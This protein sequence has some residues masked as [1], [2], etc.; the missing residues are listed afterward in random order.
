MI[1]LNLENKKIYYTSASFQAP[2]DHDIYVE[3]TK[4]LTKPGKV[5]L[6]KLALFI[7]Y[8]LKDTPGAYFIHTMTKLEELGFYQSNAD[9]YLFISCTVTYLVY[10]DNCLLLY[11]YNTP[12]DVD[13]RD[14]N[15]ERDWNTI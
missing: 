9:P 15:H 6:L 1:L 14:K 13:I 2:L 8:G 5:W 12:E 10:I 4:M 11:I 3:L 7:L